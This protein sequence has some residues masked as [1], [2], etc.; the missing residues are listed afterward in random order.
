[1]EKLNYIHNSKCMNTI[2]NSN[3]LNY[4]K[5]IRIM[6]KLKIHK[7]HKNPATIMPL[8]WWKKKLLKSKT[9]NLH[10]HEHSWLVNKLDANN[11]Q[12]ITKSKI[13]VKQ[14]PWTLFKAPIWKIAIITLEP[15]TSWKSKKSSKSKIQNTTKMMIE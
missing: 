8:E 15:W 13:E 6:N 7:V 12:I 4:Q 9:L 11:A 5:N 1:M 14:Y 10:N 3:I 2:L